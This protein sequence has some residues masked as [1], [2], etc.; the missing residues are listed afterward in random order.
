LPGLIAKL[1]AAGFMRQ[2]RLPAGA[3][4]AG[5]ARIG[6]QRLKPQEDL[7]DVP[8]EK[9]VPLSDTRRMTT[10]VWEARLQKSRRAEPRLAPTHAILDGI[11]HSLAGNGR[12]TIGP[13]TEGTNVPL[14]ESF[15]TADDCVVPLVRDHG[16]LWFVD[17]APPGAEAT[18]AAT[19]T[20]RVAIEAGDRLTIRCGPASAEVIFAHCPVNGVHA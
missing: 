9:A 11:G 17:P 15:N 6:E 13:A 7:A 5:A 10:T 12:F 18:S 16:R 14:P 3:A 2:L 20:P 4:A 19:P 8:V 1:R